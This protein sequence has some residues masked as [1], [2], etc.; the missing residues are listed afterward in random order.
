M[1]RIK[2]ILSLLLISVMSVSLLSGCVSGNDSEKTQS[3]GEATGIPD[4][5]QA[6]VT[7][8]DSSADQ[9]NK[10]DNTSDDEKG[11]GKPMQYSAL[12]IDENTTYQTWDGFGTSSCWWSQYVGSWDQPYKAGDLPVREQIAQWLYSRENGIGL[13][14]YRY[15][16]GAG[17]ADSGLGEFWDKN[18]RA[19]SFIGVDGE[20]NWNRDK[21]AVW[22]L[23]RCVELGAKDVVFFCNSP[24]DKL[25]I[26]G[27]AHMSADSTVNLDPENY[28]DFA[29]YVFDVVEHFRAEGVPITMISPINEPQWE[30]KNGQEGCHYEPAEVA[31]V[32]KAFVA[33]LKARGL[34]DKIEITAPESG[35]WGGRTREYVK[36]ILDD[37]ALGAYFKKLD[38]HSYWSNLDA[39]TK[40]KSWLDEHYPNTGLV[41]SEWCEMVNGKDYTMDSAFNMADVMWE[42][43]TVLN[44]TSWQYW[45][46][47]A[48]GD[49]R[50]GMIDVNKDKKAARP[51]RRLWTMGNFSK[52]IRPGFV[53]VDLGSEDEAIMGMRPI[54]FK[55]IDDGDGK[56]KLAIVFIN[57]GDAKTISLDGITGYSSYHVYTTAE[58]LD[59]VETASGSVAAD[60]NYEIGAAS[61][62][63]IVLEK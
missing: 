26:N 44:I 55:G 4:V 59:L 23:E 50:D 18:R 5:T 32:L 51:N 22:F 14:I 31:G 21:N 57:R 58:E 49:Y 46:G 7:A 37:E 45:V 56:E 53:R 2:K 63:T 29:K 10:D 40:F 25:T 34:E 62:V 9:D 6:A 20:Y 28:D 43:I 39:K 30:W 16:V 8:N 24:V 33:E 12:R 3:A 38:I 19:H 41:M 35:E 27:M 48:D 36:A 13:T 15:N 60:T 11:V 54:A 42:D 52:F 61:I 17:S 47:V 1:K